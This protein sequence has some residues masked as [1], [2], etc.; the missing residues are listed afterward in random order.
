MINKDYVNQL[1][2][3]Y[4][5]IDTDETLDEDTLFEVYNELAELGRKIIESAGDRMTERIEALL[6]AQ[7]KADLEAARKE[8]DLL[9]N[10]PMPEI[11][12]PKLSDN[13]PTD[14]PDGDV[15]RAFSREAA[16]LVNYSRERDLPVIFPDTIRAL[17]FVDVKSATAAVVVVDLF[18]DVDS[19]MTERVEAFDEL[20]KT[21]ADGDAMVPLIKAYLGEK[22]ARKAMRAM[23]TAAVALNS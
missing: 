21:L 10:E 13:P 22:S 2:A 8:S 5:R 14:D 3:L 17:R 9:A 20:L 6:E 18:V 4:E 1:G 19:T 7:L 15:L 16:N 12:L 23:G 11:V